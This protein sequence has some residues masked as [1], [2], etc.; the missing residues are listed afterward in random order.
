MILYL[1]RPPP[2]V[3]DDT[4]IS[5]KKQIVGLLSVDERSGSKGGTQR[6]LLIKWSWIVEVDGLIFYKYWSQWMGC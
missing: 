4:L 2:T 6:S 5:Y 3:L 1:V